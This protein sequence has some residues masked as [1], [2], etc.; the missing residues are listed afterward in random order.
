[1][2]QTTNNPNP[3]QGPSQNLGDRASTTATTAK[4]EV[5]SVAETAKSQLSDV[6]AVG[7][8]QAKA[9]IDDAKYQARRVLDDSRDQLRTQASEQTTKLAE[10]MRDVSQQLRG[11]VQGGSPPQGLVA[12][13]AEQAAGMTSR[14]AQQL[15]NRSPEELVDEV[16]RFARRRPGMFLAGAVGAG[17]IAGRIVRSVDTQ[18]IVEAAKSGADLD[19]G[20]DDIQGGQPLGTTTQMPAMSSTSASGFPQDLSPAVRP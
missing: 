2:S 3:S 8:E 1:M 17:F 11:V 19:G 7:G 5:G 6:A 9:V 15:E 14:L 4:D 20:S 18:S 13:I 12:D 10:S 16:R